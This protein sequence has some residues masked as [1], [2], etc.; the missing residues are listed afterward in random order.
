M[1][2]AIQSNAVQA[3]E[4]ADSSIDDGEIINQS[5]GSA[6]LATN[7]IT[8]DELTNSVVTGAKVANNS[9]TTADVAGTDAFGSISLG[10]GSVA[11]G[12][13]KPYDIT[14]G[15]SKTNEALVISTRAALPA[16]MLI[17]GQQVPADGHGI[18]TV[19]NMS[20]ATMPALVDF[21]IRTV[22]FG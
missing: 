8:A 3:A 14:V 11:N 19:C 5:M 16:G 20:G 4:I 2:S 17:Y 13:C 9:L 21:P 18:M 12:R 7:A 22:T 1:L 6:D 10:A 15:G